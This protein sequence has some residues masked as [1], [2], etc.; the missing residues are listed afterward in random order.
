MAVS[1]YRTIIDGIIAL[2]EAASDAIGDDRSLNLPSLSV[3][4]AEMIDGLHR[5]AGN[6]QLGQI[7]AVPDPAIQAICNGWPGREKSPR[8]DALGLPGDENLDAIIRAYIED[9]VDA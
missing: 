8:A 7:N 2:H 3:T 9:Y 1:G 5:V 6:R 4:V